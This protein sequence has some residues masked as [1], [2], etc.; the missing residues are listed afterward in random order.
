[1]SSLNSVAY[2]SIPRPYLYLLIYVFMPVFIVA[3]SSVV[4]LMIQ[5]RQRR[6]RCNR[7]ITTAIILLFLV[8]PTITTLL[9]KVFQ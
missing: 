3:I 4:W 9:M 2:N 6:I 5:P 7:T 8:H 1:M